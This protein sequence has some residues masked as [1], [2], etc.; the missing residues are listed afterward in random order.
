MSAGVTTAGQGG[1]SI[2]ELAEG[3]AAELATA[4]GDG[5]DVA[6]HAAKTMVTTSLHMV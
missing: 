4:G 2:V 5:A 3:D 1:L 6:V